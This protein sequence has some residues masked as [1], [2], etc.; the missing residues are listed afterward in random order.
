MGRNT[1][2]QSF[3]RNIY[4]NVKTNSTEIMVGWPTIISELFVLTL[5]KIFKFTNNEFRFQQGKRIL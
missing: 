3:L 4:N 2:K 5:L 1:V